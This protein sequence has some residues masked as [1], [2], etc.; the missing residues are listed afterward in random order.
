MSPSKKQSFYLPRDLIAR[1]F[2]RMWPAIFSSLLD[3]LETLSVD[4]L[5]EILNAIGD[6]AFYQLALARSE[7]YQ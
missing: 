6:M 4:Q 2:G 7:T 3:A 1:S 5:S